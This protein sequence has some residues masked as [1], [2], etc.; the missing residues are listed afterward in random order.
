MVSK[1]C[2][3]YNEQAEIIEKL[4]RTINEERKLRKRRPR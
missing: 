1:C 2:N 3:V 4:I